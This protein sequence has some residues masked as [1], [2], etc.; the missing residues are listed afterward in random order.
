MKIQNSRRILTFVLLGLS[1]LFF[2]SFFPLFYHQNPS[3]LSKTW[4]VLGIACFVAS[5]L[6]SIRE[7]S[8]I[9]KLNIYTIFGFILFWINI[10]FPNI[11]YFL[12][13]NFF[14]VNGDLRNPTNDSKKSGFGWPV[15]IVLLCTS[16]FLRIYHTEIVSIPWILI[17]IPILIIIRRYRFGLIIND[18][19]KVIVSIFW[20]LEFLV[21]GLFIVMTVRPIWKY[22]L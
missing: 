2:F 16:W 8:K 20:M 22:N 6:L 7:K 18:R 15:T 17:C 19:L 12:F 14:L 5:V 13:C 3:F 10:I 1:C 4:A 21:W 11:L 9:E